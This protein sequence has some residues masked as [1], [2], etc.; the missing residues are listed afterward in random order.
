MSITGAWQRIETARRDGIA[1]LL[2]HP[3]WDVLQVGIHYENTE[4]WQTPCGDLLPK[5]THWMRL[6]RPPEPQGR[7][8]TRPSNAAS[9]D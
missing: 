4:A 9:S 1:V 3:K 5:P 8:D 2:F 6:P 7:I